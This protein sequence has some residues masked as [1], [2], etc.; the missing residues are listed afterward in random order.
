AG[1]LDYGNCEL[2]NIINLFIEIFVQE[3]TIDAQLKVKEKEPSFTTTES[4]KEIKKKRKRKDKKLEEKLVKIEQLAKLEQGMEL[5]IL[6]EESLTSKESNVI[7]DKEISQESGKELEPIFETIQEMVD[8]RNKTCK[9][10]FQNPYM[11]NGL[12]SIVLKE[13]T[14]EL[15]IDKIKNLLLNI[16]SRLNSIERSQM[17]R[18]NINRLKTNQQKFEILGQWLDDKVFDI[19]AVT[20]TNLNRKEG[21]FVEKKVENFKFFWS[22]TS[23]NKRKAAVEKNRK[24]YKIGYLYDQ[25]T[26]ENWKDFRSVLDKRLQ[27]EKAKLNK[28]SCTNISKNGK[29]NYRVQLINQ[30]WDVIKSSIIEAANRKMKERNIIF[31]SNFIS[32][33]KPYSITRL[34][35]IWLNS[36]LNKKQLFLKA[37]KIV[38]QTVQTLR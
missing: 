26:T 27:K 17:S 28:L 1:A 30:T 35:D 9:R 16:T 3:N 14:Q 25:A 21:F 36:R 33:K 18:H 24:H 8:N 10:I 19:F 4:L 15:D 20:E 22:D 6:Q 2:K 23:I 5:P 34:L 11:N 37:K 32:D 12:A 31:G 38:Q 13:K 7:K 29:E